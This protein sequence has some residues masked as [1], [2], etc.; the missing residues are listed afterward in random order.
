MWVYFSMPSIPGGAAYA[1]AVSETGSDTVY[2]HLFE[3]RRP[4]EKKQMTH[5]QKR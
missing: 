1:H 4:T 2:L 5:T 3:L